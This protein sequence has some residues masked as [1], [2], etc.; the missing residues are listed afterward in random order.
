ME[1]LE[2][3]FFTVNSVR[4]LVRYVSDSHEHLL[5]RL[6]RNLIIEMC[7][8]FRAN[9]DLTEEVTGLTETIAAVDAVIQ[10]LLHSKGSL[11]ASTNPLN[12]F[13]YAP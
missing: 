3:I 8:H 9:E 10:P 4:D 13:G 12:E 2:T 11:G 6:S 7:L 5:R 1:V